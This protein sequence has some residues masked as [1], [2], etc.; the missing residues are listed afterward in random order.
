[1]VGHRLSSV[2]RQSVPDFP[3][4]LKN[5]LE[6]LSMK[7]NSLRSLVI[8]SA[9]LVA[10]VAAVTVPL[11]VMGAERTMVGELFTIPN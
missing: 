4:W 8:R 2:S 5:V 9:S 6:E 3:E 10:L 7:E 1:M 11:S